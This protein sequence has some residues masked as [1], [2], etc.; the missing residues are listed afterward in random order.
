ML[1]FAIIILITLTIL[2]VPAVYSFRFK[3]K[4]AHQLG[5]GRQIYLSLRNYASDLE[6]GGAFPIYADRENPTGPVAT[7]SEAFQVLLPRYLDDKRPLFNKGSAWCDRR[8]SGAGFDT[9]ILPGEND[10][11][12]VRGLTDKSPS[13]WPLFAN[14]FAPGTT[15][16]VQEQ[17]KPGGVWKGAHAIVVFSGGSAEIVETRPQGNAFYV[18]RSDQPSANAFEKDPEWLNGTNVQLLFP[19]LLPAKQN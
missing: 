1:I 15:T 18:P 11:V 7:S 5:A 4:M 8:I 10:W 16:Y 12:Y 19:P 3:T 2:I 17:K 13:R 6:N 14:A 9:K